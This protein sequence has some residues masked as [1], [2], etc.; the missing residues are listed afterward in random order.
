[1]KICAIICEYNPLH[2]GH[3]WQIRE[4]KEHSNADAVLCI[5]SGDF[6][7][8]GETALLDKFTRA[9]HAV[10]AGA[11]AVIQLPT[12]FATANAELFARGA[13]R[14]L[15]SIPAVKTLS[16]GAENPDKT[17]FK[18][19]AR[20][21]SNEPQ[22]VSE[23]IKK[24]VKEGVS[25]AKAR[26]QAWAGFLP[27]DLLC[28]PNNI[29]GVEYTKAILTEE[30]DIDILPLQR[31]GSGYLDTALN[32]N[33]SSATAIRNA[34][35]NG[36]IV[37]GFLPD[38]VYEDLPK[39]T[40]NDLERLEKYAILSKSKNEIAKVCDCTEGLEN[41]FKRVAETNEPLETLT[42]ARYTTSRIKRIALQNLL[43]I[44]ETLIRECLSSPLYL[45]VLAVRKQREDIL[46]ALGES[47]YPLIIRAHD[48]EK[49][50]KTAKRCYEKDIFA[51][52]VYGI[53]QKTKKKD[54]IFI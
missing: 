36:E 8:R 34:I 22:E 10:L 6:V 39:T 25:Y 30:A 32:Q 41:A 12:V 48:D 1:M 15:S 35:D 46:S 31:Q 42:S 5:M 51:E 3:L 14:I 52:K 9:K 24:R 37:R 13:I 20:Y 33:F 54:D 49:L 4:A 43:N 17:A 27:L 40:K 16:F 19:A 29:L 21:L 45:R 53:L 18:L 50:C 47:A 28:S 11:D 7:Q 44:E 2:N 38:F 23:S 26:A